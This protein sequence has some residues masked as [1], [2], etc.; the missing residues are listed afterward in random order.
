MGPFH[1]AQLNVARL[2]HPLEHPAL[3]SFVDNLD[4]VNAVADASP[5]FVWRLQEES[6]N[7]TD[8][9]PWGD[10]MIVNLSLWD[11][12]ETLRA[13]VF[14]LDHAAVLRRRRE[15]FQ[16]MPTPHLAVWWVPY[17]HRPELDEAR[18]RL[19]HLEAHGP[20]PYAFTLRT[21]FPPDGTSGP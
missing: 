2:L 17:G 13:Y 21:A 5:G 19:D 4:A 20:T 10:D 3:A 6:G 8:V 11:D 14:G 12:L 18:E 7:A 15:Y 9:R 1:L 16:S